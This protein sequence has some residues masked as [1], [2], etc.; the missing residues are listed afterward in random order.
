MDGQSIKVHIHAIIFACIMVHL[1][2]E[3]NE[4]DD[5][6]EEEDNSYSFPVLLMLSRELLGTLVLKALAWVWNRSTFL[7]FLQLNVH[8]IWNLL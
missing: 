4:F 6:E 1:D 2:D 5:N 8:K 7:E 3:N